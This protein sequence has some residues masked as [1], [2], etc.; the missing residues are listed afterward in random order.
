MYCLLFFFFFFFF[1]FRY[2][3]GGRAV[4]LATSRD[5]AHERPKNAAGEHYSLITSGFIDIARLVADARK[6]PELF[7]FYIAHA[8]F[9][10]AYAAGVSVSVSFLVAVTKIDTGIFAVFALVNQIIGVIGALLSIKLMKRKNASIKGILV[11]TLILGMVVNAVVVFFVVGPDNTSIMVMFLVL[12]FG[13]F[14]SGVQT[15]CMRAMCSTLCPGGEE[16]KYMGLLNFFGS[17]LGWLG[18]IAY[19]VINESTGNIHM[20]VSVI[21]F[22]YLITFMIFCCVNPEAGR[23]D[24][25]PTLGKRRKSLAAGDLKLGGDEEAK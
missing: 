7:K 16:A 11:G 10:G 22:M 18:P 15:S 20:A 4:M 14:V 1:F 8:F 24:V 21:F 23:A 25:R 17:L 2:V 9:S 3:A 13:G 6:Y 5:A 12:P 19:V